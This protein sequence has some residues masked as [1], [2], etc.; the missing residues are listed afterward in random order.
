MRKY[1]FIDIKSKLYSYVRRQISRGI[2]TNVEVDLRNKG[3]GR[4]YPRSHIVFNLTKP[5]FKSSY[6]SSVCIE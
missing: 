4:I 5:K 1:V 6:Q 3:S 2:Y